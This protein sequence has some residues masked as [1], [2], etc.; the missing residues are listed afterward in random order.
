MELSIAFAAVAA[1]MFQAS[2]PADPS[3]SALKASSPWNLQ[4]ADNMCLLQRSF[5]SGEQLVVLGLQ[6]GMLSEDGRIVLIRHASKTG[7][8]YGEAKISFDNGADAFTANYF[9]N[10]LK[11]GKT[12]GALIDFK[13]PK[14]AP[15]DS[16]SRINIQIGNV[17]TSLALTAV[18]KAKKALD[19][20]Q[21]DLFVSWGMDRSAVNS[22]A[23]FPKAIGGAVSFFTVNDYPDQALRQ[24][25]QGTAGVR[26]WVDKQG[27]PRD[28]NAVQ[29]SGSKILD[30]RTCAVIVKRGRFDPARTAS[31]EPIESIGFLRIRWVIPN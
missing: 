27:R 7:L 25:A 6:P 18:A 23:V 26:F 22:I 20:C 30:N 11:D 16:A 15:M 21:R 12:R 13:Q 1:T 5:G 28:C 3:A 2:V 4:Y 10:L 31:G 19:T 24:N 14:L 9:E 17:T 29:S 8:T